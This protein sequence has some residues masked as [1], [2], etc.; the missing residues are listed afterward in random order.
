MTEIILSA[1]T[2]SCWIILGVFMF[3]EQTV[4][5]KS[6]VRWYNM[7]LFRS[8]GFPYVAYA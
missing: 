4:I 8:L 2:N 6:E 5:Q 3:S 7:K 1:Q